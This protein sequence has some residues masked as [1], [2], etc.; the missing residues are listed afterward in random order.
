[1][2]ATADSVCRDFLDAL[3]NFK[4]LNLTC[5]SFKSAYI[6]AE[7]NVSSPHTRA[8]INIVNRDK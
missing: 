3:I 6:Q 7:I 2:K 4:P 1:M 5:F 8:Y